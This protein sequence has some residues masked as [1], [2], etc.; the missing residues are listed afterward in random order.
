[1]HA[2][3]RP[4]RRP[5]PSSTPGTR[6]AQVCLTAGGA[7]GAQHGRLIGRSGRLTQTL[8]RY[9]ALLGAAAFG[10]VPQDPA[11]GAWLARRHKIGMV[12][13]WSATHLVWAQPGTIHLAGMLMRVP[14]EAV[15][16]VRSPETQVR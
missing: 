14:A 4:L 3:R 13:A 12:S 11:A 1:M 6:T 15:V 9:R 10:V 5:L 7:D 16:R 2:C 8:T